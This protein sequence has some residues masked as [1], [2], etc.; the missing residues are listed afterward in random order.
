VGDLD[1]IY[2]M[3][4]IEDYHPVNPVYPV[5]NEKMRRGGKE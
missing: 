4:R 5:R 2:R 3:N 1:R